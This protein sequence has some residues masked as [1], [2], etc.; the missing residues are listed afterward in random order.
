MVYITTPAIPSCF[1][2]FSAI[3]IPL[4][5]F[6]IFNY[7]SLF[8]FF[9]I[10]LW[11]MYKTRARSS[12]FKWINF[13]NIFLYK[14]SQYYLTHKFVT[15]RAV[16]SQ[17][18]QRKLHLMPLPTTIPI[19]NLEWSWSLRQNGDLW[20]ILSPWLAITHGTHRVVGKSSGTSLENVGFSN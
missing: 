18:L 1:V 6:S 8:P 20:F 17:H 11:I 7:T 14:K 9:V 10:H 3:P 4:L 2:S 16:Q 5:W 19:K 15:H 12:R 13:L